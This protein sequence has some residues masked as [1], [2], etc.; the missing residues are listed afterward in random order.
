[1]QTMTLM[2]ELKSTEIEALLALRQSNRGS[3]RHRLCQSEQEAMSVNTALDE[4]TWE[5]VSAGHHGALEALIA[6]NA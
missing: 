5:L 4:I 6:R 2:L 3:Q 1:M